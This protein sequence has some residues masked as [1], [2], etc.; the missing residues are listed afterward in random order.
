MGG[1]DSDGEF[2]EETEEQKNQKLAEIEK[3]R[4]LNENAEM[5]EA[6]EEE[7]QKLLFEN[8]KFLKLRKSTKNK[9]ETV[10]ENS[11]HF[12]LT[13][14]SN[15]VPDTTITALLKSKIKTSKIVVVNSHSNTVDEEVGMKFCK[16]GSQPLVFASPDEQKVKIKMIQL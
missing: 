13:E 12:I 6:N 14:T 7:S 2:E 9:I 5:L 8:S 10:L 1:G 11:S 3:R 4:W 16:T 15:S